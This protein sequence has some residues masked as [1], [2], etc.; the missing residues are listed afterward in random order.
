MTI[1]MLLALQKA[2]AVKDCIQLVAWSILKCGITI[3][4]LVHWVQVWAYFQGVAYC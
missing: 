3:V 1:F 2:K 4:S